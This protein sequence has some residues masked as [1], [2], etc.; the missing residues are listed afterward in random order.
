MTLLNALTVDVEDY[1]QVSAFARHVDRG[2]WDNY[3]LRVEHNTARVLDLFD[4]FGV[5]GTFF[6]LGWVARRCPALVRSIRD[7]GH[8]IACHG[9]GHQLIYDLDA[10]AFRED[11]RSAKALLEDTAGCRVRGYRAPSYSITAR[12]LWALDVLI[13]EGFEFDSSVFPVYHDI[14]G[15]PGAPRF[16][17]LIRRPAG[18]IRE[19]PLTTYPLRLAG[20]EYLLPVAGGGYLRLFPASFLA[21]CIGS[22]NG[23]EGEPAVL[24]F[25]PWE[26]DPDQP[27]IR[28]GARSRFRHY[29][30]LKRTE[31]KLSSLLA[32]LDFGTMS[33]SIAARY[34]EDALPAAPHGAYP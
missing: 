28:A 30:N 2:D 29:L 33:E 12:S 19:F 4:R 26:L 10:A 18:V 23:R 20:R 34:G 16:P 27:R 17:H 32:G 3:P 24:Y 6:V 14:Y 5:K 31:G 8:E 7:R 11:V 1:F 22:I 15:L 21:R 25:H 9:F 13:E